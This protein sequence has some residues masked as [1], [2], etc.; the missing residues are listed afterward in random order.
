MVEKFASFNNATV[1]VFPVSSKLLRKFQHNKNNRTSAADVDL[2]GS[3]LFV[4][5]L[6]TALIPR[7]KA[8]DGNPRNDWF[9]DA[10]LSAGL[11]IMLISGWV[12]S[13]RSD[14]IMI[15][16]FSIWRVFTKIMANKSN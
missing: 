5:L 6:A 3:R 7:K 11:S 16:S 12:C 4:G 14:V 13:G 2:L 9:R 10:T 8:D 15:K 1:Y